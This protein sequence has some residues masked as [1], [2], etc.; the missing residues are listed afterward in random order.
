MGGLTVLG[1]QH[2]LPSRLR[3]PLTPSTDI[4]RD[5]LYGR[6]WVQKSGGQQLA[7]TAK[8]WDELGVLRSRCPAYGKSI[9]PF[10]KCQ[11]AEESLP[12]Q[13]DQEVAL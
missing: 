4:C 5:R 13:A 7:F 12:G 1:A 11:Q 10:S 8:E 9:R 2:T 6:C 3:L